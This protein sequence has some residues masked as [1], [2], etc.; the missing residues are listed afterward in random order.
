M[1]ITGDYGGDPEHF[2]P[3]DTEL[4]AT[5]NCTP[6]IG[7]VVVAGGDP[8]GTA[9]SLLASTST[10]TS[11]DHATNITR[12]RRAQATLAKDKLEPRRLK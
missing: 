10:G 5:Y 4:Q 6:R 9:Q 3:W 7:A 2:Y 11:G 1:S 12:D 8:S